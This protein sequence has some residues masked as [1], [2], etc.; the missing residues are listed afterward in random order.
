V[1]ST[2]FDYRKF[3]TWAST[4]GL[5][6]V[7]LSQSFAQFFCDSRDIHTYTCMILSAEVSETLFDSLSTLWR[8]LSIA[9]DVKWRPYCSLVLSVMCFNAE[10]WPISDTDAVHLKGVHFRLLRR[11]VA[12]TPDEHLTRHRVLRLAHRKCHHC[13][14][15]CTN[16][17]C[18]GLGTTYAV[19]LLIAVDAMS[20][21]G[22]TSR[23]R[24]AY[25][26]SSRI[27]MLPTSLSTI[28]YI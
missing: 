19:R 22:W 18:D 24:V 11:I 5:Q 20:W 6:H 26:S 12:K 4:F 16:N 10:V 21:T 2:Q 13:W 7:G 15:C 27:A 28:S 3:I 9:T 25:S 23:S 14:H 17:A 8:L 1:L